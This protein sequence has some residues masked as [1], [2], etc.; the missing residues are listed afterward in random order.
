METSPLVAGDPDTVGQYQI[1]GRLGA[2]GMGRVYLGR[3]RGGRLVAVKVVYPQLAEDRD[4]RRRFAREVAAARQ[5]SGLYT[6]G[7]IDADWKGDPAW[8]A[9]AYVPGGSLSDAVAEHGPWPLV[10]VLALGAG[11]AEALEEIHKAGVVHRDL[12]PSNVLLAADGPRLIDFG[13]ARASDASQ[14]T[15]T[16]TRVGTPGYMSPEQVV[17]KPVGSPSDVFSLGAVLAYAATGTGPFGTGPVDALYF[18]VV[19]EK[20]ELHELPAELRDLVQQCLIKDPA[21]RPT[22]TTLFNE[23]DRLATAAGEPAAMQALGEDRWLPEP[24][25]HTLRMRIIAP[26]ASHPPTAE[27][28][29]KSVQTA[30]PSRPDPAADTADS[31]SE[32]AAGANGSPATEQPLSASAASTSQAPPLHAAR[33]Q[34]G[35]GGGSGLPHASTESGQGDAPAAQ[36]GTNTPAAQGQITPGG[37]ASRTA[38]GRGLTSLKPLKWLKPL[39]PL[40]RSKRAAGGA[41]AATLTVVAVVLHPYWSG[42]GDGLHHTAG[43]KPEED[44]LACANYGPQTYC[45]GGNSWDWRLKPGKRTEAALATDEGETRRAL[46]GGVALTGDST[47]CSSAEAAWYITSGKGRTLHKIAYGTVKADGKASTVRGSL[48][49]SADRIRFV[50][51]LTSDSSCDALLSWQWPGL[52]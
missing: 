12:K 28:T 14:L 2:G 33:T 27:N 19:Y 39:K 47:D 40:L 22:V 46:D 36:A 34:P 5:V 9:T 17:G 8:L 45:L 32:A 42:P 11:L 3:T 50:A 29:E 31:H 24:V 26:R 10:S 51:Y 4:F 21:E 38:S 48:P 6:A 49:R 52:R 13:I 15:R 18:R 23:L 37:A 20:P 44:S 25:A 35:N 41:L 16:G 7:V 30:T 1:V 43:A